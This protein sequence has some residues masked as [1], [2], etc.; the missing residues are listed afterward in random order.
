MGVTT[1]LMTE[2]SKGPW[3][4]AELGGHHV[5]GTALDEIGP[6]GFILTVLRLRGLEEEV[7]ACR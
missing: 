5:G 1:E 2:D 6:H 7:P 3:T 4:I